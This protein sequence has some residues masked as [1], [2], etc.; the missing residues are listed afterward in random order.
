MIVLPAILQNLTTINRFERWTSVL[1][2][3]R[4]APLTCHNSTCLICSMLTSSV[5]RRMWAHSLKALQI[6]AT[7]LN[8]GRKA[9]LQILNYLQ[10]LKHWVRSVRPQHCPLEEVLHKHPHQSKRYTEVAMKITSGT[11]GRT[12]NGQQ[13][14]I[15]RPSEVTGHGSGWGHF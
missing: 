4:R 14:S 11:D 9:D 2:W 12:E 8:K 6:D 13:W 7:C 10:M 15:N 5:V 1:D 3:H